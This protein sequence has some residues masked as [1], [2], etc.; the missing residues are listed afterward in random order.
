[1]NIQLSQLYHENSGEEHDSDHG[2]FKVTTVLMPFKK[3]LLRLRF[4]LDTTLTKR[5]RES[6]SG[7][8]N[9][10]GGGGGG[11]GLTYSYIRVH[12]P[13]Q[14]NRFQTK[15]IVQNTNI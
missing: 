7:A 1:M 2:G 3:P 4:F 13:H 5:P 15:L 10:I 8:A 11:G 9:S 14:T 6:S 12:R